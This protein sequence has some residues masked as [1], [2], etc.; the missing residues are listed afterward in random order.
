MFTLEFA[1]GLYLRGPTVTFALLWSV[2]PF[3]YSRRLAL[4]W[5]ANHSM[6][7]IVNLPGLNTSG[8]TRAG[9]R[10]LRVSAW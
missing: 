5:L 7:Y 6:G 2:M 4:E 8:Q 3:G 9:K 1:D 10:H